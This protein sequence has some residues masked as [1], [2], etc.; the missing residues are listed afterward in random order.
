M[1]GDELEKRIMRLE[2]VEAIKKLKALYCDICDDDHNPSRI[3]EIF[4]EDGIWEG[5]DFGKAQ[6]RDAIRELFRGFQ[7]L[8]SFSQHNIFNPRI[9]VDGD[10]A[11]GTWYLL[12]PF[13]FREDNKAR[14]IACRYDD[15]YVKINGVWKYQ[16]LRADI[17]MAA[18]Y[19]KGWARPA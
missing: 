18:L 8:I 12:G 3:T 17:R 11:K 16:H 6:G 13:T 7:K 19:E 4:A 1:A 5:G 10:R 14:W 9:E 15:D 2:D